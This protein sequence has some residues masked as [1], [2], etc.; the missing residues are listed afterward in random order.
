MT[1][2]RLAVSV[3][4]ALLVA[5][6]AGEAQ[7]PK[8]IPR[9]GIL[10]SAPS[11]WETFWP[12]L[13]EVGYVEGQTIIIERRWSEGRGERFPALAAELVRLQ[14]DL[15]VVGTNEPAL[16]A[17]QATSTIP[18]V[19]AASHDA[20]GVGLVQSL[21]RPGG[22]VTGIDTMA[23]ELGAKRLELLREVLPGASRV[24][25]LYNPGDPAMRLQLRQTEVAAQ[26]FGVKIRPVLVRTPDD[27]DG[28][29]ASV[30]RDRPDALIVFTEALTFVHRKR[31]VEFAAK[32]RLPA[33]Y[34]F[35]EFVELGGL[36][37]Y[38]PN[39]RDLDRRA[40]VYIDKILK[41]TRPADL[42]VEQPTRFELLLNLRTAR[43]LGLTIPQSV[44][45]RADALIQ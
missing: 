18:I 13:R 8:R 2:T 4:L 1:T 38:G 43:A 21:A 16:A 41:G 33:M 10:G 20:V 9:I 30:A 5:P 25:V 37:A 45:L 12:A 42:P 29:F 17:K 34:E 22:N 3:A 15:I 14:V 36:I 28:V 23:P 19:M 40:A 32:Q 7:P 39:L 6:P 24:A 26:T 27:F 31:I 11:S 44:L 35:R